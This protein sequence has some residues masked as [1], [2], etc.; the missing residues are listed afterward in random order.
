MEQIQKNLRVAQSVADAEKG[1][2]LTS[3][4]VPTTQE[5][6]FKA[7]SEAKQIEEWWAL[8]TLIA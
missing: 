2:I 8:L 3:V 4:D 7:L 6:A 1:L 5:K